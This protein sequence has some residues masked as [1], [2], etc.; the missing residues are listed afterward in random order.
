MRCDGCM[1]TAITVLNDRDFSIHRQGGRPAPG[2]LCNPGRAIGTFLFIEVRGSDRMRPVKIVGLCVLAFGV[3]IVFVA[4]ASATPDP[5]Y[6]TCVKAEPSNTGG[7][8]DKNCAEANGAGTGKYAIA[9]WTKAKKQTF[10]GKLG[11]TVF[12][13]YWTEGVPWTGGK[14]EATVECESGK[15]AGTITGPSTSNMSVTLKH[16]TSSGK[17][18]LS[19]EGKLSTELGWITGGV[20]IRVKVREGNFPKFNCTGLEVRSYSGSLMAAV[21]GNV[22]TFSKTMTTTL[23]MNIKGGQDVHK[24]EFGGVVVTEGLVCV[25][26]PPGSLFATGESSVAVIKGEDLSI[27]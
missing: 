4:G 5:T 10:K 24:G 26:E 6:H 27:F 18:C 19:V 12:K 14:L 1:I 22:G 20:G 3:S 13:S 8:N 23:G 15:S 16:C 2:R 25:V 9:D 11:P 17:P 7:F 21:S